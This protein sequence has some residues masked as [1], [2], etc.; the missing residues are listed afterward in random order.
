MLHPLDAPVNWYLNRTVK[1]T[2]GGGCPQLGSCWFKYTCANWDCA[3]I[4][5]NAL[6]VPEP[7]GAAAI[8]PEECA[9]TW[10]EMYQD[11]A[12]LEKPPLERSAQVGE[13]AGREVEVDDGRSVE[14]LEDERATLVDE[15]D[16]ALEVK[17]AELD[18][19]LDTVLEVGLAKLD[20]L[21]DVSLSKGGSTGA[22]RLGAPS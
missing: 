2:L 8:T 6:V 1:G 15:L 20:E 14:L 22:G 21:E 11:E 13:G 4:K 5:A 16:V 12:P 10:S 9:V 19:E 7:P 3:G 17:L 18:D